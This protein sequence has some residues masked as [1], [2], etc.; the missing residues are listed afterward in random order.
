M[1][2]PLTLYDGEFYFKNTLFVLAISLCVS[3]DTNVISETASESIFF[4]NLLV[5]F[6]F[7]AWKVQL[8]ACFW[9]DPLNLAHMLTC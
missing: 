7:Q 3:V 2:E 4:L 9:V 5:I 8:A 6:I 1:L